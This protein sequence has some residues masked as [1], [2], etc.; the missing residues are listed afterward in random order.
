MT[1]QIIISNKITIQNPPEVLKD[2]LIEELTMDNPAYAAA[3]KRGYSTYNIKKSLYEFDITPSG[4]IRI[5]R[6]YKD[7]LLQLL[8]EQGI[9][10]SL[11][12][13]LTFNNTPADILGIAEM[14][15]RPYQRKYL[16]QLLLSE[17]TEGLIVAPPGSGKTIFAI[18]LA[19][20]LG[21][22]TLWLTHRN[23]L[24]NQTKERFLY[25]ILNL[26]PEDVGLIHKGKWNINPILTIASLDTMRGNTPKIRKLAKQFGLVI[27]DECLPKGSNILMLD[28]SIKDISEIKNGEVTTFGTISNKFSRETNSLITLRGGWGEITGTKT[29]QLP[30]ITKNTLTKNK[31]TST[32]NLPTENN[33]V[34]SIMKNINKG[35][36]LLIKEGNCHTEKHTIGVIKSRLLALIAC[37]GHIEKHSRCIQVGIVKDKEWFQNEMNQIS[38]SFQ[39]S[40][41]RTSECKR[42]DLIIRDYSK[43]AITFLSKYIPR[44]KKY[45]LYVPDIMEHASYEDIKN[46]L[47]VVF[48]TEGGLNANQITITMSTPEFLI[49]IQHLLKKFEIVSRIIPIK[50]KKNNLSS[51]PY[52]R[53]AMSGYDS[54]LFYH[55]IGF[56]MKRKQEKLL[57]IIRRA[58]KFVRKVEYNGVIY[59]CMEVITK[60]EIYKKTI[61]YD[62]TT[63]NHFFIANGVL[64]SNCHHCPAITFNKIISELH[65]HYLYGLTATPYR[66]DG[67]DPLMFH[68]LGNPIVTIP[69][70]EVVEDGGIIMPIVYYRAIETKEIEGNNI[71]AI[72]KI[73]INN[74]RRN[75]IIVGDVISEAIKGKMNIVISN[76]KEHCEMLFKLISMGWKRTGIV[77]GDYNEK[78]CDDQIRKLE[79]REITTLV[80][81][82]EKFGEGVDIDIL[83][84]AF[85]AL[86]FR[87]EQDVEQIIGRIQRVEKNKKEAKVFDY[88]DHRIGVLRDQFSTPTKNKECRVNAYKRLGLQIRPLE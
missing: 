69:Q 81:T 7:R 87:S 72:L 83:E 24:I 23:L 73:I 54:F 77:T 50:P 80:A 79:S 46:Y 66:G 53:L 78:H 38:L 28:G 52:S 48:D 84:N 63:E 61:V 14:N 31:H 45:E 51:K 88:V 11:K 64:S 20:V 17:K 16:Y 29:H 5:P 68:S 22:S 60:K 62:F 67:L 41:L 85:L 2:I 37:D 43:E 18:A 12:N 57:N 21:Q 8:E 13:K 49:G 65:P 42:G 76:R 27:L 30:I 74:D 39:D 3:Q 56:S 32:F 44:G 9:A 26:R 58:N 40:D 55:K 70:G 1:T 10:F 47:Q 36:F 71:Q 34:M 35:D 86:P 19:S 82:G 25:N 6:G 4:D 15:L 33:V 75:N 59:R